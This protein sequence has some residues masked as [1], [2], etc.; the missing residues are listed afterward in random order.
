MKKAS[1]LLF[2]VLCITSNSYSQNFN[3]YE[4]EDEW[5]QFNDTLICGP[6]DSFFVRHQSDFGMGTD[7]SFAVVFTMQ[8]SFEYDIHRFGQFYKGIPVENYGAVVVSRYDRIRSVHTKWLDSLDM[9][10]TFS[11]NPEVALGTAMDHFDWFTDSMLFAWQDTAWENALIDETGDTAATWKPEGELVYHTKWGDSV[12]VLC[13]RYE[14]IIVLDTIFME[15]Y[16]AYVDAVEDTVF[17]VR[18]VKNTC[19]YDKGHCITAHNG[20][21]ANLELDK[22]IGNTYRLKNCADK[23][24][25]RKVE[26]KKN[27]AREGLPRA[28]WRLD[29]VKHSGGNNFGTQDQFSTSVHWAANWSHDYF[30]VKHDR[31]GPDGADQ[32]MRIITEVGTSIGTGYTPQSNHALFEFGTTTGV[33]FIT[34]DL[35]GHELAHAYVYR[36]AG[37]DGFGEPGAINEGLADI[38]GTAIERFA[39]G[40]Y[41]WGV[42]EDASGSPGLRNL[43]FGTTTTAFENANV[44]LD[45]PISYDG[46]NWLDPEANFD[47][48][49]V[50]HNCG[51]ISKCFQL[52]VDGGTHQETNRAVTSI[53]FD[54]AEVIFFQTMIR[55]NGLS[56]YENLRNTMIDVAIQL[57]GSCSEERQAVQEAWYACDIGNNIDPC[58]AID[59][60]KNSGM[61]VRVDDLDTLNL[62]VNAKWDDITSYTWD[63]VPELTYTTDDSLI[64]I[65]HFME[66]PG[67]YELVL[68]ATTTTSDTMT[69]TLA[70]RVLGPLEEI[71][72]EGQFNKWNPVSASE[73]PKLS[74]INIYPNPGSNILHISVPERMED[75]NMVMTSLSGKTVKRLKKLNGEIDLNISGLAPGIYYLKTFNDTESIVTKYI[76]Y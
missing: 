25:T 66:I 34:L 68:T 37:L 28:W 53:G 55:L 13:W 1:Y 32:K 49:G 60:W 61:Y 44:Q 17:D 76:K 69:D 31:H 41:D 50:H 9:A 22:K 30:S 15:T 36:H 14:K 48:G 54:K 57:Y 43:E 18:S 11:V 12:P 20:A 45:Q 75:V 63:D 5:Y 26:F 33:D 4:V 59:Q 10:D 52:L 21:Q 73:N 42:L 2:L 40:T 47:R 27:G 7:D 72:I 23:I 24:E 29:D 8:D 58:V 70:I 64:S 16:N 65:T 51:V 38:F 56:D 67:I 3:K 19:S 6:G 39:Q 46:D 35:V 74:S 62:I 71:C